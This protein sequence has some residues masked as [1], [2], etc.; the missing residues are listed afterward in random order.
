[1]GELG[2]GVAVA[3]GR[4]SADGQIGQP[5]VVIADV[6]IGNAQTGGGE[7]SAVAVVDFEPVA[8]DSKVKLIHHAGVDRPW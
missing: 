6:D 4:V 2:I 7:V 3:D 8:Q 5:Q 1:M